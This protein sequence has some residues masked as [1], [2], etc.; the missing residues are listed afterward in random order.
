MILSAISIKVD[1][2]ILYFISQLLSVLSILQNNF[3]VL[4]LINS[5]IVNYL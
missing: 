3:C 2:H 5:L 4:T 1:I